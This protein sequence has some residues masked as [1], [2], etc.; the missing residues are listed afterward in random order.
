MP[1][2]KW[3]PG[4]TAATP[5]AEAGAAVLAARFEVVRHYLPLAVE[6]PFDD[7]ESVHQ[8]RVGT[9][10]AAAALRVFADWLPGKHFRAARSALRAVR[11]AAGDARDWDVFLIGLQ[12]SRSLATAAGRP[13]LDFLAGYGTGERSAAQARLAEA[14]GEV[15]PVLL[16]ESGA[17]PSRIRA[18][19]GSSVPSNFGELATAHLAPLLAE[20]DEA[21]AANPA[22]PEGLHRLRIRGKRLRYGLE[23]FAGCFPPGFRDSV[24]APVEQLQE[25]LGG[26]QDAAVGL[27]RLAGLGDR[28]RKTM[29]KE[30]PRLRKGFEAL[31][32][33]LRSRVPAGGKAFRK[34]RTDWAKLT[35]DLKLEVA[36]ATVTA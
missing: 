6:E 10:R 34:W 23:I 31:T 13:A 4:L 12:A 14:A 28:V 18:P 35:R 16:E 29:P 36:A 11:R 27:E 33:S 7:P 9:R 17:L 1:D 22:D 5:V 25:V 32:R 30:W 15:G 20:F 8:L 21:V 24:Y 26:I 2:G 3:I 19:E